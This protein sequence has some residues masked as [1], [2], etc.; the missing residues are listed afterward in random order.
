MISQG[1]SVCVFNKADNEEVL[2]SW[3]FTQFLLTNDVQTAYSETEGYV[4]VTT[5]AQSSDEYLDYLSREGEDTNEHY[6]VK[7]EAAKLLLDNTEN[8]FVTPVWNGSASLRT[9]SGELIESVVKS[10]RRHETIDE[11]YW[12]ELKTNVTSLYR[13]DS[14]D[15]SAG[16]KAELGPLP[17][18]AVALLVSLGAAWALITAYIIHERLKSKGKS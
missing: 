1:P 2:A 12:E 9:A 5:K 17:T 6:Y 16:G 8:T 11:G 15:S 4:P 14:R 3:L 18:E 7:I 10:V 13:L